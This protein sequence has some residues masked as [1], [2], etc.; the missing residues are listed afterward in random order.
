MMVEENRYER[1]CLFR[2]GDYR[3][4][5]NSPEKVSW[6]RVLVKIVFL[7]GNMGHSETGAVISYI[8]VARRCNLGG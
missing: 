5:R 8:Q 1:H 3:N 7:Y 2:R 6:V 4:K